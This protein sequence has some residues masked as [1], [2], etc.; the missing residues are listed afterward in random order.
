MWQREWADSAGKLAE[1][2]GVVEEAWLE[3]EE[4]VRKAWPRES[5]EAAMLKK[6]GWGAYSV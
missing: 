5:P 2:E 4:Q 1:K 3:V 6:P